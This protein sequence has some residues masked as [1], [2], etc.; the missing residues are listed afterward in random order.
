MT[1]SDFKDYGSFYINDTGTVTFVTLI[2]E[3]IFKDNNFIEKNLFHK[4]DCVIPG[5]F[6]DAKLNVYEF[7][8]IVR[9]FSYVSVPINF[10]NWQ[11][12]KLL[13]P[14]IV[15]SPLGEGFLPFSQVAK[16]ISCK[17]HDFLPFETEG[18]LSL[19]DYAT[20]LPKE[21]DVVVFPTKVKDFQTVYPK[22]F[23]AWTKLLLKARE[24]KTMNREFLLL[25]SLF[26]IL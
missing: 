22:N 7:A 13:F 15:E 24:F 12:P 23:D 17:Q 18:R 5:V 6:I 14:S 10:G 20:K 25:K 16:A 11:F 4:L 9:V 2:E 1:T 3:Q 21:G 8:N 19:T 26:R